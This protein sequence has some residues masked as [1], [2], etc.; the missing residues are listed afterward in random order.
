[1]GMGATN[2]VAR[3]A[4]SLGKLN[5]VEIAFQTCADVPHGGVLL[6]LPALLASGLLQHTEKH[7]R[8]PA[9]Y[10]TIKNIFLLVAFLALARIKVIESLRY[11]APGEWGKLLGI[12]RIPEAK[13]LREKIRSLSENGAGEAWSAQLCKE[14]MAC[15]R[16]DMHEGYYYIDG[17]V[18]VYCGSRTLLPKHYVARQRLCLRAT[19]DYWVNAMDG[20]PFF[21][22]NK[23]IDPG[24][25]TVLKDDIVPR[26]ESDVPQQI[27]AEQLA[28]NPL[29]H[30]FTLVFDREGYSPHFFKA[31]KQKHIACL[32]YH[33]HPQDDWLF[34]E[35]ID[36]QVTLVTGEVVTMK[37]AERGV[38]LRNGLW[39]REIRK[40]T[41]TGHQTAI[42]ATDYVSD[43][44]PLAVAMFARWCQEAFFKYMR[45][46]Y[47]LDRLLTY[48]TEDIPDT[49]R[50][51]NPEYKRIEG[52]V[53]SKN[54]IRNRTLKEF[55]TILFKGEIASHNHEVYQQTKAELQEKI[56][57]LEQDIGKLKDIRKHI[58]R[59]IAIKELSEQQRFS[60][61]SMHS[62]Y[63]IDTI[64]MIAYRA[65]TS[66][67]H[68]VRD[69]LART[70]EARRVLQAVYSTPVDII[71][72]KKH[73]TLTVRLH[74]LANHSTDAALQNL[75][76]HLNDTCTVFPGTDLRLIYERSP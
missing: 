13:I 49:T 62:K 74:H 32:T 59:H 18:R 24:L 38:R 69:T 33:K 51:V 2:E 36:V 28:E 66:M 60:K 45:N 37:L 52:L 25:L 48:A 27:S 61:L 57:L 16:D 12:D 50:I 47:N 34:T 29:R 40:L 42:L 76:D 10:Y 58:P 55:G 22:I 71:P 7:F 20:Q 39:V 56:S 70:D 31:M 3:I 4:A 15:P 14:W 72:N 54:A 17:H 35:F 21:L 68:I 6:A 1:M 64:K 8:L 41:N 11:Y 44:K 26:L 63:F 19:V 75:C 53:R 65:E 67:A 43:L 23:A 5:G 30:R 46:Q 73:K 9:G